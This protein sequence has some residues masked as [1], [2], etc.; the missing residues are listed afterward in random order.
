MPMH[1]D[2]RAS[3]RA[4]PEEQRERR[5]EQAY[6]GTSRGRRHVSDCALTNCSN[7]RGSVPAIKRRLAND[8]ARR[9]TIR[10]A[11]DGER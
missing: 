2:T 4:A 10:D 6:Q 11:A 5:R 3:V 1:R 9:M 7:V 8:G